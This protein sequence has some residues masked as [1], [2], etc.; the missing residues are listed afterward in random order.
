MLECERRRDLE[1]R[2]PKSLEIRLPT[3]YEIH[4]FVLADLPIVDDDAL[5]KVHEMWRR[6]AT[7][8]H[9]L[10]AKQRV[11][12]RH[13]ASLPVCSSNVKRAKP[14]VRIAEQR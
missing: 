13:H 3:L 8:A 14:V 2:S 4:N 5:A 12:R 10:G 1:E 9:S 7:D 6:I 11:E